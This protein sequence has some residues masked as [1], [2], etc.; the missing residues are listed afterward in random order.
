MFNSSG[1]L[2]SCLWGTSGYWGAL[3][4]ICG[5]HRTVAG[6]WANWNFNNTGEKFSF[7]N[8]SVFVVVVFVSGKKDYFLIKF[9]ILHSQWRS[10]AKQE[11]PSLCSS[12]CRINKK[13]AG[14]L[15]LCCISKA[16]DRQCHLS[17][18]FCDFLTICCKMDIWIF[19]ENACKIR[20]VHF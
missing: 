19:K 9:S 17:S 6:Q 14:F 10:H 18:K 20:T 11:S 5:A 15:L 12:F 2:P 4:Y 13:N 8:R 1:P 7:L 16:G 3:N